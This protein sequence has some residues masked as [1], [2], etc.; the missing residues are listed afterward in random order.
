MYHHDI[1][2]SILFVSTVIPPVRMLVSLDTQQSCA[3]QDSM[4][5][6][7]SHRALTVTGLHHLIV[8]EAFK[9]IVDSL[10]HR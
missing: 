3:N 7:S 4:V 10:L 6:P 9:I 2:I 5:D 1:V 8:N